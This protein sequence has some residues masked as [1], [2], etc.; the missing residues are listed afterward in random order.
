MK[1]FL[2]SVFAL[3]FIAQSAFAQDLIT[4]RTLP[5]AVDEFVYMRNGMANSPEGGA[6]VFI[7]ALL[8]YSK[9]KNVGM[10]CLTIALDSTRLTSGSTYKGFTPDASAAK[11]FVSLAE[12]SKSFIPYSYITGT[13][14][15]RDYVA[16][17]PYVLEYE[18]TS[19]TFRSE[20]D[21]TIF[22]KTSGDQLPRAIYLKRNDKG[23]WKVIKF[24]E[25]MKNVT[26]PYHKKGDDL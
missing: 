4:L 2:F 6:S 25:V 12:K 10:K 3:C 26:Q 20:N 14:P 1:K 9:D 8:I 16:K 22:I 5:M 13:H 7:A 17:L 24:D 15:D 23:I 18:K 11:M 19:K 21:A